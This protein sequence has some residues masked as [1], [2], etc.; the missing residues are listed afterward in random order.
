MR[1]DTEISIPLRFNY[2]N[3]LIVFRL[4]FEKFQ[5]H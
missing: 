1:C 4:E 5:F 3:E 2:N